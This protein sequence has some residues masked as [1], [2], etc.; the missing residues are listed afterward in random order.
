[1]RK[2]ERQITDKASLEQL[3]MQSRIC[4]LGLY[5]GQW[6]YV[7]PVNMGYAAGCLYF[8]SGLKGKKMEILRASPKVCF[9]MDCDVEVVTG[10]KPCNYTTRY[11]SVIGFGTAVFVEDEAEKLEGL[12]I[13]MRRHAGPTEG[14]RPEILPRTAVVRID[15]ESMTGKANP[16]YE[17]WS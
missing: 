4:R 11:K 5:D 1:M 14:F 16:P 12:R 13:I 6:P 3:L 7:V 10:E 8:H 2:K 9:E 17:E 15:I